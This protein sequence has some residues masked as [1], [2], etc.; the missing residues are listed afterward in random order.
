MTEADLL[1]AVTDLARWLG[2]RYFHDNDSRRN[3]RGFPDVVAAGVGGVIFRELKT[4]TGRLRP[5]QMDWISI[6]QL[7]GADV[8]V[9][10]PVDLSSGVIE[11]ELKQLTK[12][13]P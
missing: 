10:R 6:L 9:W 5:E 11:K 7:G 8:A 2:L 4:A 1:R 3:R 12:G 13:K